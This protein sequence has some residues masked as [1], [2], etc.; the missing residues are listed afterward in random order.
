[1]KLNGKTVSS[2]LLLGALG[3]VAGGLAWEVIERIATSLGI[4]LDLSIGPIGFDLHVLTVH[5]LV[6]PGTLIGLVGGLLIFRFL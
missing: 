4:G 2:F 1:M 6:N 3:S 5:F